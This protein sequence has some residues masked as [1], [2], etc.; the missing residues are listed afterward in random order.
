MPVPLE[1]IQVI[2]DI[3]FLP[4]LVTI[5]PFATWCSGEWSK[6][7]EWISPLNGFCSGQRGVYAQPSLA[8]SRMMELLNRK[9]Y[10]SYFYCFLLSVK[11]CLPN[12]DDFHYEVRLKEMSVLTEQFFNEVKRREHE[13]KCDTWVQ[14][15]KI[16]WKTELYYVMTSWC[17]Y[18]KRAEIQALHDVYK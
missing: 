8:R 14:F 12:D 10:F 18:C 4:S 6:P 7:L 13:R 5:F 2:L 15:G 11:N 1:H 9:F 16:N 17:W 3:G